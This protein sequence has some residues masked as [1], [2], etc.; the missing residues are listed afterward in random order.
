MEKHVGQIEVTSL[1]DDS[2]LKARRAFKKLSW[3]ITVVMLVSL[4]SL[5][6]VIAIALAKPAS[7]YANPTCTVKPNPNGDSAP[8]IE[9]AFRLCGHNP[10]GRGKVVFLNETY[11]ISTVMNITGLQNVD[12][13]L[14]GTLSWDNSDIDYWLNNSLPVGYQNQSSA[15]LFGG[16]NISWQGYGYGTLNGNGQAWYDFVN[17]ESNYPR[18]PH[19]ITIVGTTNST[20]EG[21]N[22]LNSQMWTMAVVLSENVLLQDIYVNSTSKSKAPARN[23]DGADTIHSNNITF[24]RWIV[25]NDD[26]A[27]SPKANS[28]N[29]L[30]EDCIFHKGSGIALGSI[31]QYDDVYEVIVNVTARNITTYNTWYGAYIKTWT[32]IPKGYPPNGGGGGLGYISNVTLTDFTLHGN[33]DVFAITQCTSYN[34]QTGSCDT[35]KFNIH[36]VHLAN[37]SGSQ[38]S[39]NVATLQCSAASPCY[40]VSIHNVTVENLTNNTIA[41]Q[42]QCDSVMNPS[43][44]NCTG[45]ITGENNA[46]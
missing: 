17:G 41:N 34:G 38:N 32:G 31:G 24:R 29:I 1:E 10:N 16:S 7:H 40:N 46:Y 45:P 12:V 43:G 28:T 2:S 21:T 3:R 42:Y 44:F 25:D 9:A 22:F 30:I 6:A 27:I 23:T 19:Q 35:S 37:W 14:R 33:S 39:P 20:F 36:N 15:W 13:D 8:A 5:S 26:D 4:L 18:R 11:T